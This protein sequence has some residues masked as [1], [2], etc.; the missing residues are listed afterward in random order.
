MVTAA[1]AGPE[2]TFDACLASFALHHLPTVE[3]KGAFLAAARRQLKPGG[4]FYL[5][6][7]FKHPGVSPGRPTPPNSPV[8]I[9]VSIQSSGVTPFTTAGQDFSRF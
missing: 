4:T 1:S 7:T 8:S 2:A 5:V 9:S 3:D 6:D